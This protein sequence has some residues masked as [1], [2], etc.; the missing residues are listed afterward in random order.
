MS[1][2][3][4]AAGGFGDCS[5]LKE[6]RG[7]GGTASFVNPA[8][9]QY[10]ATDPGTN[11]TKF[12][13]S[14]SSAF[15]GPMAKI[16][17]PKTGYLREALT[18]K[19]PGP[20]NYDHESS[21]DKQVLSVKATSNRTR[22][23]K[24]P[25]EDA[26]KVYMPGSN[27]VG[28]A[29]ANPGPGAYTHVVTQ[30]HISRGNTKHAAPKSSFGGNLGQMKRPALSN[31]ISTPKQCGPGTYTAPGGLGKQPSSRA[32]TA[33]RANFGTADRVKSQVAM[34]PGYKGRSSQAAMN[35]GPG[36]Y[37]SRSGLGLQADGKKPTA[38][39]Y[40]FGKGSRGEKSRAFTPGPGAYTATPTMGMQPNSRFAT[41]SR[42]KFGTA[43]RL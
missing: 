9:G 37:N 35:P 10:D 15:G 23:A 5:P 30:D 17:R 8:P 26:T 36:T 2:V 14:T 13:D 32:K 6:H 22:F 4:L 19:A 18:F 11:T 1:G 21:I 38:A 27:Q 43:R 41:S 24:A 28:T 3:G 34:A 29:I 33:P 25:R 16:D 7:R 39:R 31:M 12:S 40:V 42:A 20:G